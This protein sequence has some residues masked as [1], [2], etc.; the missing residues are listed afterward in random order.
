MHMVVRADMRCRSCK[1]WVYCST[2]D[3]KQ[4]FRRCGVHAVVAR[5][6]SSE[7]GEQ[8]CHGPGSGRQSVWHTVPF[9]ATLYSSLR[10]DRALEKMKTTY[11]SKLLSVTMQESSSNPYA[12]IALAS[13]VKRFCRA[14]SGVATGAQKSTIPS[15]RWESSWMCRWFESSSMLS[16]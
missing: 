11:A 9:I 1:A 2:D 8:K 13:G 3:V 6:H 14:A 10:Q 5:T 15:P 4:H 7:P 16:P 12:S